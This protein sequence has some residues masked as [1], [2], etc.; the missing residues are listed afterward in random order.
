MNEGK[1]TSQ[2][3]AVT[4]SPFVIHNDTRRDDKVIILSRD[5]S[6]NIVVNNK[7]E[8]FK[9]NSVEAVEDAFSIHLFT[10]DQPTVYLEGRTDEK[11]YNRALEVFGCDVPFVFKWIG[12]IDGR[13]QE[14]NS[15]E[16]NLDNVY[17]FLVSRNLPIRNVCLKDCDTRRKKESQNN[18]TILSVPQFDNVKEIQKGIENA[19]VLDEVSDDDMNRF[20]SKKEIKGDYGEKK[21]IETF[22]KMKFCDFICGMDK[23]K[24]TRVFAH[25]K[26]T[27]DELKEIFE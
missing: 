14:V 23:E 18:V 2:I 4:H 17:Q 16:K 3:F 8:Y 5:D 10:A 24:L 12:Y 15:G 19:L 20:Y 26:E 6:G 1:Q 7:A 11:Y 25:L 9:C 13:E 21:T 27:I 22:E